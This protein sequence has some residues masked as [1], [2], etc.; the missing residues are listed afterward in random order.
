MIKKSKIIATASSVAAVLAMAGV[1]GVAFADPT[2]EAGIGITIT[3]TQLNADGRTF[4]AY[5]LGEFSN[6]TINDNGT[7]DDKAD[8]YADATITTVAS[9]KDAIKNAIRTAAGAAGITVD[10]KA[11]QDPL[12][13][14]ARTTDDTKVKAFAEKLARPTDGK[15]DVTTALGDGIPGKSNTNGDEVTFPGI[16]EGYYLIV[17][18]NGNSIIQATTIKKDGQTINKFGAKTEEDNK[19]LTLGVIN[20]KAATVAIDKKVDGKETETVSAGQTVVYTLTTHVPDKTQAKTWQVKDTLTNGAY[21]HANAAD[22]VDVTAT[23]K[24]QAYTLKAKPVQVTGEN[25]TKE[26]AFALDLSQMLTDATVNTGDEVVLTY[27]AKVTSTKTADNKVD[28]TG[29]HDNGTAIVPGEDHVHVVSAEI[30]FHKTSTLNNEQNLAG[31][32]FKF[33]NKNGKWLKQDAATKTWSEATNEG[34]ATE[35][36]TGADGVL[37]VEGLGSGDYTI[38]ET[39]APAGYTLGDGVS[40][41]VNVGEPDDDGNVAVKFS[42]ENADGS[43]NVSADGDAGGQ[44]TVKNQPTLGTLAHTGV[45]MGHGIMFGSIAAVIA[46]GLA[47]SVSGVAKARERKLNA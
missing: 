21:V 2:D 19:Q 38:K 5:K 20:M 16:T 23:V 26:N 25:S 44:G 32:K 41:N 29:T 3:G 39:A 46:L 22:F 8:D 40:F 15:L 1:G 47:A 33:Q 13:A 12:D 36:A 4:K 10:T 14:V 37:K 28:I 6:V 9:D 31:A 24:G 35:F 30:K 43:Y 18:S 11:G 17:D 7:K 45:D 42:G 27:K 34:E